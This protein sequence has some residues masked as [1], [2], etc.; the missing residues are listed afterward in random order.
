M[1]QITSWT[2]KCNI[3]PSPRPKG[4]D[5][6]VESEEFFS[7]GQGSILVRDLLGAIK[8]ATRGG[9]I[10][11]NPDEMVELDFSWGFGE[12]TN[13]I[14]EAL[15]LWQGIF[16]LK[17]L[18]INDVLVFEDSRMIINSINSHSLPQNMRLRHLL[19]KINNL[20]SFFHK[21][22]FFHILRDLNSEVDRAANK[23]TLMRK[24][25]LTLNEKPVS[26]Q[27]P[28]LLGTST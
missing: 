11:L 5:P 9:G 26:F 24:E 16:Q 15:A 3:G 19:Q 6:M 8:G 17:S 28:K 22:E 12:D 23:A 27:S 18:G 2:S 10:F 7:L 25:H 14:V 20:I 4:L 13:N 21:I 1:S